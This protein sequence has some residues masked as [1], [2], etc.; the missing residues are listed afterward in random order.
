M[1]DQLENIIRYLDNEMSKNERIDFENQIR[2]DEVLAKAVAF[3]R[4][5]H[6]F[7]KREK[8]EL[9]Q[10]LSNLGDEFIINQS[11]KKRA[12]SYWIVALLTIVILSIIAYFVFFNNNNT[13]SNDNQNSTKT[14][15]IIPTNEIKNEEQETIKS[16]IK[17]IE[18]PIEI[19]SLKPTKEIIVDDQ[20]IAS[21]DEKV[22]ERN[23]IM[24][25][26]ITET[27]RTNKIEDFTIVTI[28]KQDEVFKYSK[29]IPFKVNG[30]ST[31]NSDYQLI[32]Y[33]NRNFD[34]QNDYKILDTQIDGE[35][36]NNQYQFDFNG[37][38]SLEKGLYY[39][40]IRKSGTRDI[41]HISRF[42]VR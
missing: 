19:P 22:Y 17:A 25:E 28:P 18:S 23:A 33:S 42:E 1:N 40:V 11:S 29:S 8:P 7:L 6:G 4:G 37:N 26:V 21:L 34:I 14:E 31:I 16:P 2:K 24:E 3:Q 13:T 38:L 30:T 10:K 20:P 35:R 39:L 27:Y 9:E 36:I 41:L 5:L 32:I 15:E 12:S